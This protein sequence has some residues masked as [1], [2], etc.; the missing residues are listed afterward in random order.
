VKQET[1]LTL[2]PARLAMAAQLAAGHYLSIISVIL[3]GMCRSAERAPVFG[4]CRF[5]VFAR[6]FVQMVIIGI[7]DLHGRLN[8]LKAILAQAGQC[9]VIVLAGDLTHFGSPKDADNIIEACRSCA[10]HIFA[11]A[12][13]CDN[14]GIETRLVELGVGIAGRGIIV[15]GVGFHGLSGIP[16]WRPGMYQFSEETLASSLRRGFEEIADSLCHVLVTHVPP[17]QTNLDR[18]LWGCHVGSHA[19]REFISTCQPHLVVCGHVHEGRG[20]DVQGKTTIVN[21]GHAASGYYA[22]IVLPQAGRQEDI[23]TELCRADL[24]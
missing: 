23:Q 2:R 14:E 9:D 1:T 11:V 21:C 17:R 8:I 5:N 13:N 7:S 3:G 12:G 15:D 6:R 24:V 19:V 4:D 10:P 22:K 16:P 18:V 20:I